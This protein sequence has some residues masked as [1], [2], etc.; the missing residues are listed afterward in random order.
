MVRPSAPTRGAAPAAYSAPAP[1]ICYTDKDG[2]HAIPTLRRK[3]LEPQEYD[4]L[5]RTLVEIAR[6]QQASLDRHDVRGEQHDARL[7]RQDAIIER[8][9][10]AIERLDATQARIETLLARMIPHTEN[11]RDA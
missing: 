2:R 4:E 9:T 3:P 11:G 1:G 8:L 7:E 6:R 10:A 5:L